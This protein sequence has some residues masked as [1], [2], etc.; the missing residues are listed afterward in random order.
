MKTILHKNVQTSTLD[1]R[2][3]CQ[4]TIYG[5][6]CSSG[7]FHLLRPVLLKTN[8]TEGFR[9]LFMIQHCTIVYDTLRQINIKFTFLQVLA[10][11]VTQYLRKQ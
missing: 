3:S 6:L 8:Q 4:Q 11:T 7:R 2:S 10:F 5:T 9:I 1:E